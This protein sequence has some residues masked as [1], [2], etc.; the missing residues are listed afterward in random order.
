MSVNKVVNFYNCYD[1]SNS[2]FLF[3]SCHHCLLKPTLAFKV[4]VM[5]ITEYTTPKHRG[6]LLTGKSTTLFWGIFILNAIETFFHWRNIGIAGIIC[7]AYGLLIAIVLPE[8]RFWLTTK[9]RYGQY[10]QG[11]FTNLD[12]MFDSALFIYSYFYFWKDSV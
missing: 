9:Q 11:S 5:M 12:F 1:Q 10:H 4:S 3:Y 2:F 7:S 8:S 6:F